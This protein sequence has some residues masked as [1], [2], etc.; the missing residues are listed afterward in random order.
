MKREVK[1]NLKSSIEC[2]PTNAY[3]KFRMIKWKIMIN[4]F[5]VKSIASSDRA[6]RYNL[7]SY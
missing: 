1:A 7:R 3:I 5:N 2:S 6:G 4:D